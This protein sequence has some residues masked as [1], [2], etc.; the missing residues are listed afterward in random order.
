MVTPRSYEVSLKNNWW[1]RSLT[2]AAIALL[3]RFRPYWSQV[4]LLTPGICIKYGK[5]QHL[6]SAEAMQVIAS[7]TSMPVPKI[8]CAFERKGITYIVMSRLKGLPIGSNWSQRSDQSKKKLLEQLKGYIDEMRSLKPPAVGVVEGVNGTMLYDL[9]VSSDMEGYGPF[10]SIP[11]FHSFLTNAVE[12]STDQF[13]EINQ[14]LSMYQTSQFTTC[15]T[16]GDLNSANILVDGDRISGIVDWDTCGWYPEYWE[17]TTAW[18]VNPY[19]EFWRE[20]VGKFLVEYPDALR[21]E[22]IRRKYF[23]D[24]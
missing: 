20:E 10:D 3:K 22:E 6:S 5:F 9:R 17:Y 7:N 16:H 2:L 1:W 23:G 12:Q 8:Y 14:L 19:N 13:P 4:L 24:F 18:N 11:S 15:F 21:M